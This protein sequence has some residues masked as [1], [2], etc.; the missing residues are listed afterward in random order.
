M[1][2]A[3]DERML[4][5]DDSYYKQFLMAQQNHFDLSIPVSIVE[6]GGVDYKMSST[7]EQIKALTNI[8]TENEYYEKTL[9]ILDGRILPLR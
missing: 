8:V 9:V 3:F 1:D 2:E 6:T 5:K 4:A 7:Q